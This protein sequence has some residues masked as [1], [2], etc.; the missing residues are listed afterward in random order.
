MVSVEIIYI[1]SEKVVIHKKYQVPA[2]S[3]VAY[4]LENSGLLVSHPEVKNYAVGIFSTLVSFDTIVKN[5]D[6]IEIYRPLLNDPKEKRRQR[7]KRDAKQRKN[8][9]RPDA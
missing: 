8:L 9:A 3:T 6:R 1:T 7:A 2:G 4:V 5:G